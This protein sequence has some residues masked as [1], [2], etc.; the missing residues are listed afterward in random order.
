[1]AA[2][3]ASSP[4]PGGRS[5]PGPWPR[6]EPSP[7]AVVATAARRR[8]GRNHARTDRTD[9][10][11]DGDRSDH[12]AHHPAARRRASWSPGRP[13]NPGSR[14]RSTPT[15]TSAS[16]S[17]CSTCSTAAHVK[18]TSFIVGDWLDANPDMGEAHRRRRARVRQPHVHP[19]VVPQLAHDAQLDEIVRCRDVLVRLTG[20]RRRRRSVPRAPTTARVS[21]GD[22]VLAVAGGGRVRDRARLRRRPARLPG[23]RCRRR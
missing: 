14:S 10:G 12:A 8:R 22:Q 2:P 4:S 17:S 15:A 21:P 11:H 19:S 1:M 16:P 13:P 5:S 20:G 6:W 9:R 7:P 23:P 3:G 18:M